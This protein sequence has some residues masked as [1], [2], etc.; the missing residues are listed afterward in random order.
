MNSIQF[1]NS[2]RDGANDAGSILVNAID[3]AVAGMHIWL[4]Q[5]GMPSSVQTWFASAL[6][7]FSVVLMVNQFRYFVRGGCVLV[8]SLTALELIKPALLALA[9]GVLFAGH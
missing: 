9:A 6:V 8:A 7:L 2:F 4:T 1:M 5:M 3:T